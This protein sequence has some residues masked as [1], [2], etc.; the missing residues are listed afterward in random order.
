MRQGNVFTRVCHSVWGGCLEDI[1][2]ADT[3]PGQTD[4][5]IPLGR[6]PPLSRQTHP[7]GNHPSWADPPLGKTPPGQ[8]TPRQTPP[9]AD[10]RPPT[11]SDGHCSGQYAS[12][13]NALLF[14]IYIQLYFL[15]FTSVH[16]SR[17]RHF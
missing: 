9:Q 10:T 3:P 12:Y 8:T 13:W 15:R 17:V 4:T 1:P 11:P 2:R 7:L 16:L 14:L 6:P 5:H